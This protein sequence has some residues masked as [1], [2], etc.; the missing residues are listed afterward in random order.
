MTDSPYPIVA[1]DDFARRFSMRPGAQCGCSGP[2]L[3]SSRHSRGL[4]HDLG[5]QAAALC[6]SNDVSRQRPLPTWQ[7]RRSTDRSK[8]SS[9]ASIGFPQQGLP[10]NMPHCSKRPRRRRAL[11]PALHLSIFGVSGFGADCRSTLAHWIVVFCY[12]GIAWSRNLVAGARNTR[13]L[14]LVEQQVPKVAA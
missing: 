4:G 2:S 5:I 13:F 3:R 10:M 7:I 6:E 12:C 14:R 1:A 11:L 9:T 8:A